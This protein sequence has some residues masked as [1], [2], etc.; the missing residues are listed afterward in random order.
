MLVTTVAIICATYSWLL[1]KHG[2]DTFSKIPPL[3][4]PSIPMMLPGMA[5][6]PFFCLPLLLVIV[7]FVFRSAPRS[8]TILIFFGLQFAPFA[9][10]ISFWGNGMRFIFAM[11][12]AS[13]TVILEVFCRN[14]PR[15][16]LIAGIASFF[17]TVAWYIATVCVCASASV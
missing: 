16:Q 4:L 12:L 15:G 9:I 14:L 1:T 2:F 8:Y 7:V 13:F 11:L 3:F 6:I 17:V 10:D 5:L